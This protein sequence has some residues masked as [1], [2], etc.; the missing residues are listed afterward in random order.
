MDVTRGSGRASSYSNTDL[1]S[2]LEKKKNQKVAKRSSQKE[3]GRVEH[4]RTS[5]RVGARGD[6]GLDLEAL[7]DQADFPLTDEI[8]DAELPSK[9]K[10][11]TIQHYDGK[12]DPLEHLDTYHPWME[13]H[14]IRNVIRC[15]AFSFTLTGLAKDWF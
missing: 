2:F 8:M 6:E 13:L 4:R 11:P 12:N 14:G 10:V 1:R 9:F 3:E 5:S 7:I 15:R